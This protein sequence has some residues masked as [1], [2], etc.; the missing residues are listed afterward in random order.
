CPRRQWCHRGR[1]PV[2]AQIVQE[3]AAG[4]DTL[5]H[6]DD[7]QPRAVGRHAGAELTRKRFHQ[8]PIERLVARLGEGGHHVQPLAAGRLEEGLETQPLEPLAHFARGLDHRLE[9]DIGRRV[10]IEHQPFRDLR[11]LRRAVPRMQLQRGNLR[12]S[13]QPFDAVDLHIGLAIAGDPRKA[14]QAGETRHGVA[15]KEPLAADAVGATHQG[16]RPARDVRQQPLADRGHVLG[17]FPLG[18][19]AAVAGIRPQHF[20]GVGNRDAEDRAGLSSR[21]PLKAAWRM[22]PPSVQPANSISATSCGFSQWIRRPDGTGTRVPNGFS[23]LA[24]FFSFGRSCRTFA[25]PKPVPMRPTGTSLPSRYTPAMSE[26]RLLPSDVQPPIT[27][28]WPARHL[29]FAQ[30]PVRPESYGASR[31]FDTTPSRESRHADSRTAAPGLVKCSRYRSRVRLAAGSDFNRLSSS[32]L[33]S[34]SGSDRRSRPSR[35]MMSNANRISAD[36]RP[37]ESAACRAEKSETPR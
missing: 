9:V 21:S 14:D 31:R 8:R 29:D 23:L 20:V 1:R 26:L 25:A 34:V 22:L 35:N 27:T 30:L 6:V 12:K 2:V 7:I 24:S 3:Y 13:S 18:H 33:R 17:E 16:A 28:S 11:L 10:E 37:S 19:R 4:P 5:G 15:L 36:S 32:S